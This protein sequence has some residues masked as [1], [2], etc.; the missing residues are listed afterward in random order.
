[1]RAS[2]LSVIEV[3]QNGHKSKF[4]VKLNKSFQERKMKYSS[5]D[6]LSDKN[7][8]PSEDDNCSSEE[9]SFSESV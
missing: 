1:M 7:C 3:I 8:N 9:L 6:V 4:S 5:Q 2:Y